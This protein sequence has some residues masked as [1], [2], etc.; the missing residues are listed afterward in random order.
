[1]EGLT[2][3]DLT[4]KAISRAASSDSLDTLDAALALATQLNTHADALVDHF[5]TAARREGRSWTDIGGRLGVSKQAARKRF[6]DPGAPAPVLPPGVTLR[7]RLQTCLTEAERHA[8]RAGAPE[9]SS[10]HLL[11]GLLADGV[12]AGILDR[13]AVTAEA[14]AASAHRLVGPPQPP[15]AGQDP[16]PLSAEAVCAI[17]AAAHHAQAAGDHGPVAVG[18]E[19]LLW[20]LALDPGSRARRVLTD[21]GVDIAAIKKELACYVTGS[22][23]PP[24]RFGRRRQAPTRTCSFCGTGETP[25]RPLAHGPGVAICGTCAQRVV[26][27]L[28]APGRS[29]PDGADLRP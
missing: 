3:A 11:A 10:E 25:A 1:M 23:R 7:P 19:H 29:I 18:T 28:T 26:Q 20:V 4:A 13:L 16:P 21:L 24:R 8:R 14:V 17:E 5:V 6:L 12:A 15:R 22:P 9:V 2:L 27:S